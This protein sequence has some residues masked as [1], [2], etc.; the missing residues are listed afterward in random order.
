MLAA[1]SGLTRHSRERNMQVRQG[2]GGQGVRRHGAVSAHWFAPVSKGAS[3]MRFQRIGRS[4]AALCFAFC[5]GSQ[6][7]CTGNSGSASGRS[8]PGP[9]AD[10][11]PSGGGGPPPPPPTGTSFIDPVASGLSR[12]T[13]AEYS[14]TVTDVLGE[15][16]DAA[17]RYAFPSDPKEHGFDNN[18]S[19][20]HISPKH[21]DRFEAAA[22]GIAAAT[23]A[24]PARRAMILACDPAADATCLR[25]YIQR[26]GRRLYRRQVTA[27]ETDSLVKLAGS[28]TPDA[29]D[30]F[31]G[32]RTV[33]EA[34][35]QSPYFLFHV[36]LGVPDTQRAGV[37]GLDGFELAT[38]LSYFLLGTTPD[39]ALLDQAQSGTLSS[40][41]GVNMIVQQMLSDQR[42]RSGVKRFYG[43]WLPLTLISGPTADGDRIPHGDTALAADM[44][45]ESTL[46]VDDVFWGGAGGTVLDL[47]TAKYTFVNASLA[48]IYGL[49]APAQALAW[50]RVDF[51]PGMARAGFLTQGTNLAAGSH[52]IRPSTTRRGQM[53][54]EQ[55]LCQDVPPPPPGV[56]ANVPPA[57]PGETEQQTFLRHTT[58]ATCASCHNLMDPIGLGLSGFDETGAAR[59]KDSNGQP[60]SVQGR[61]VG[62]TPPDFNGPIE[63][64]QK[65]AGSAEFKACFA[66]QLFRYVY[67]RV[68][69]DQDMPGIAELEQSFAGSGWEFRKGVSALVQSAGFRYRNKGDEP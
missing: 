45:E 7:G 61:V 33:L 11:G 17:T 68:E 31:L 37:V 36:E 14:Q 23:F 50:Q 41:D 16:P 34:M 44:V 10:G 64:A 65:L 29:A 26:L 13:N 67:G 12:L 39:D 32:P 6:L 53:V 51:P 9:A 21:G 52:G 25:T 38:R 62:F 28:L 27:A 48:K 42:V 2:G 40:P 3:M 56:N 18:T 15:P 69:V 43:Q 54:R 63:L 47:L 1:P 4:F 35:L 66:R 24:A 55:L 20:L 46:F 19:L 60:V 8:T 30:P 57:M 58:D 5:V 59:T 22:E 49:P